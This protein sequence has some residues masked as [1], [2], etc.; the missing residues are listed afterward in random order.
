MVNGKDVVCWL[1][2]GI[3]FFMA[4]SLANRIGADITQLNP[5]NV[6]DLANAIINGLIGLTLIISGSI[7]HVQNS[8]KEY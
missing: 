4:L 6:R 7:F 2:G 1:I 3:F 5:L 8:K